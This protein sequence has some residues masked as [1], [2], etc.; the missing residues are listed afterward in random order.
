MFFVLFQQRDLFQ[1]VQFAVDLHALEAALH[2]ISEFLA[3]FPL[4]PPRNGGEEIQPCALLHLHDAVDHL[5]DSLA[6]DGQTGGGRIGNADTG[7]EQAHIVINLCHRAH[8][9]ARVA[10]GG[11]LFN[12]N[13]WGQTV[14]MV[15]IGLVHQLQ[16]LPGVGGKALH[17]AALPF[18]IDG[19][20]GER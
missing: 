12:G 1:L 5:A 3:V 10:R 19:I 11:L 8:G 14:D 17:I 20:E 16:E 15:H 13:G 2:Q 6:L 4:A 9:G 7:P 18:G